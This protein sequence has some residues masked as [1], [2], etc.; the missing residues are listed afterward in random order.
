M[1]TKKRIL[2]IDDED[3]FSTLLKLNIE[4]MSGHE[5]FVA[6]NGELGLAF[7][8]QCKPDL[9]FLDLVMP[10]APGLEVLK[11]IKAVAP[12]TPVA[13]LTAL[14]SDEETKRCL[15]AGAYTYLTKPVDPAYLKTSLLAK[16][17]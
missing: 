5:V 1:P 11:Q 2:I 15:D 17:G 16:L 3:A 7:V 4:R 14:W 12:G 8:K 13:I 10:G 9:V 6:S